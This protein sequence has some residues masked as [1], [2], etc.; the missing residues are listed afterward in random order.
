MCLCS[1]PDP[2]VG[3]LGWFQVHHNKE[4]HRGDVCP[5]DFLKIDFQNEIAEPKGQH[6]F[7]RLGEVNPVVLLIFATVLLEF[8]T[9]NFAKYK[10]A[11]IRRRWKKFLTM[12]VR[13]QA[14]SQYPR[15]GIT[16][17]GRSRTPLAGGGV[18][19]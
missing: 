19:G 14:I 4:H 11:L 5:N 3:H 9:L 2:G 18:R 16:V 10:Q 8:S 6:I 13:W 7:K 1:S 17:L 12:D 15:A